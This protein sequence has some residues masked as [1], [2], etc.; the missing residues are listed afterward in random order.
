[1][2]IKTSTWRAPRSATGIDYGNRGADLVVEA[3]GRWV[4]FGVAAGSPPG[5]HIGF[6]GQWRGVDFK[7]ANFR[8]GRRIIGPCVTVWVH[9]RGSR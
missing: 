8:V 2:R 7:T 1:M 5:S 4:R 6:W 3:F 9:T